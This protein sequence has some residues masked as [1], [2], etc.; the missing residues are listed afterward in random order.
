M[1]GDE[2]RIGVPAYKTGTVIGRGGETIRSLKQQCGCEI[3]LDKNG[4]ADD[5]PEQKYFLIRGPPDKVSYAQQLIQERVGTISTS[6]PGA[7][8]GMSYK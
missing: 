7:S 8:G 2:T 3:E 5:D 4:R 6:S 1:M